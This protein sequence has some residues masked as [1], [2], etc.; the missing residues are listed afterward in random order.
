MIINLLWIT[1]LVVF[2]TDLSGGWDYILP[3]LWKL[4]YKGL[5]YNPNWRPKLLSCSLC[6]TWW[7]GIIYLLCTG[8]FT[9][10]NLMLVGLLAFF[11]PVIKDI[12]IVVKEL[13]IKI[14]NKV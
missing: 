5:P 12:L 14:L 6:Q 2:L 8:L 13:I 3:V 4:L 10:F 11:T 9:W 7:L 1:V